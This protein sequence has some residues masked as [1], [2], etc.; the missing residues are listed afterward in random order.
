MILRKEFPY[1]K[2]QIVRVTVRFAVSM[3]VSISVAKG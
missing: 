3:S 2:Q 1:L